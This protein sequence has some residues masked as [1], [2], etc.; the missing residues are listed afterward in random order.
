MTTLIPYMPCMEANG[1]KAKAQ[2]LFWVVIQN[3]KNWENI[4]LRIVS[5]SGCMWGWGTSRLIIS[6]FFFFI[7]PSPTKYFCTS[8]FFPCLIFF[9]FKKTH[10]HT[11]DFIFNQDTSL[12]TPSPGFILYF[13]SMNPEEKKLDP[14]DGTPGPVDYDI[15]SYAHV[16]KR[17]VLVCVCVCVS[18]EKTKTKKQKKTQR[19][20]TSK[21]ETPL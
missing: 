1:Q 3:H 6:F 7:F 21:L 11:C 12:R 10:T 9:R 2:T 15:Q 13:K 16:Q 20:H 4:P 18:V 8:F 5:N 19:Q 17:Q 14:G